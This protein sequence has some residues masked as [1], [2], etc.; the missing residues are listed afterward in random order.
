MKKTTLLLVSLGCLSLLISGC[1]R[2]IS[3]NSYDAR[4]I[5]AA[6]NTYAGVIVSMR[7]V[8]VEEGDYLEDN[9]VGGIM[10]AVAGGVLGNA[11]GGGRG[12]TIATAAGALA[13][14]AA[15][16]YAEKQLKSQEGFEYTVKLDAG[17][18]KTVVQGTDV[19]LYP[20]QR[21]MLIED[22]RGRSRV[23]AAQ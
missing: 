22:N 10:G 9:K 3:S 21:V 11:V 19:V 4:T 5:G 2:N 16:A 18:M 7:K 6:S 14:A 1:A 12:R 23:V 13:G 17:G 20:G 15:G 8:M